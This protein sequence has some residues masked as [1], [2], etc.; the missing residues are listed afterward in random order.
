[1]KVPGRIAFWRVGSGSLENA[2]KF[3]MAWSDELGGSLDAERRG[4][5]KKAK[6]HPLSISRNQSVK[7]GDD[8]G[9]TRDKLKNPNT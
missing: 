4:R 5:R 1:M 3:C 9:K 6:F 7:R 8:P 2:R